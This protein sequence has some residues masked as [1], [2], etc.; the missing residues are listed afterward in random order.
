M[1]KVLKSI[2]SAATLA[3]LGVFIWG[4]LNV[5]KVSDWWILRSY[6]PSPV[7]AEL[8]T[9]ASLNDEGRRLFYIYDPQLLAKENFKGKCTVG[10]ETIVLGCYISTDGIYILDVGDERLEGVEEVTAAHEMLHAVYDRLSGSERQRIDTL[11]LNYFETLN[12]SRLNQTIQNYR[13][14][15]PNI[16]ANELHSILGTE[17]SNLPAGLE[18]H[19]SKYFIDRQTVVARAE[20]YASEFEKR[21]TQIKDFDARLATLNTQIE[22]FQINLEFKN[23]ALGQERQNL[24]SLRGN[25]DAYNQ[26]VPVYNNSV[27][28]FNRDLEELKVKIDN[29]NRL[30]KERNV[31]ALE[32]QELVKAIDTR[33]SQIE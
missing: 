10:E 23:S 31:I 13:A 20:K 2:L 15:D 30:V 8:A 14:R 6:T 3:L 12:N 25:P 28:Q 9:N 24:E 22:E 4:A 32:E 26:A 5:Q 29:Y 11:L 19:Y 1:N 7:V 21:E 16:V 33:L 27:N 17:Y 18:A